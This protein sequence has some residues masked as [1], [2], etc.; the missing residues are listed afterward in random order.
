MGRNRKTGRIT[1]VDVLIA[2]SALAAGWLMA[3]LIMSVPT[4]GA[5]DVPAQ[6]MDVSLESGEVQFASICF[7]NIEPEPSHADICYY[8]TRED[9]PIPDWP[10]RIVVR[11]WQARPSVGLDTV[12]DALQVVAKGGR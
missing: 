2:I 5:Q 3:W 12:I 11:I 6:T 8:A 10:H 4:A 7:E 9:I 1:A